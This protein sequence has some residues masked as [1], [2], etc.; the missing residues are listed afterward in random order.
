IKANDNNSYVP[1]CLDILNTEKEKK[2]EKIHYTRGVGKSNFTY[3]LSD[4]N[5][6]SEESAYPGEI[7][8]YNKSIDE[9]INTKRVYK[10]DHLFNFLPE[11]IS[12]KTYYN[13][14]KEIL[15][16]SAFLGA[17]V[18]DKLKNSDEDSCLKQ[19]LVSNIFSYLIHINATLLPSN[20]CTNNL[21]KKCTLIYNYVMNVHKK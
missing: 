16:R 21:K 8:Q 15:E 11:I 9:Y 10:N 2:K 12:L 5:T 20:I 18:L 17:F 7:I 13:I 14:L 6:R 19:I 4:S 1:I 3:Y